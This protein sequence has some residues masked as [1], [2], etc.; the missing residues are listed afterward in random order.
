MRK[1]LLIIPILAFLLPGSLRAQ[2]TSDEAR[3]RKLSYYFMAA[4][5]A[6]AQ[7]RYA[8]MMEYL[9]HCQEIMPDDPATMFELGQYS[10][11][12]GMDSL[13]LVMIEQAVKADPGNPWYLERLATTY[14][15]R[16][17]RDQALE[18][19]EKMASLQTK[20]VDVL[21]Q[22]FML[23]KQMGRTED[24]IN[25]LDRIQMLQ[26]NNLRIAEQKYQLYLDME[27][28]G[29]ALEQLRAVCREFPY[30]VSSHLVLG[31]HYMENGML[32]SAVVCME[33]AERLDPYNSGLQLMRLRS[34]LELGDTLGYEHRRDSLILNPQ[35]DLQVRF[36]SMREV[37]LESLQ[38][39][40]KREHTSRIFDQLLGGEK[41]EVE[42]LQLFKSYDAYLHQEDPDYSN[43]DI[44]KR[45]V[46]ADPSVFESQIELAQYYIDHNEGANLREVCREALVYFPSET[47]F[48]YFLAITYLQ[49][50]MLPEAEETLKAGIRQA[51]EDESSGHIKGLLYGMLGDLCHEQHREKEAFAAYDSCLVYTPDE[52]SCL[53]NYAYY[54]SLKGE[55]LEKAE[56]MSYQAVKLQPANKTYL[57]TYAWVL[58]VQEDYT[59]ARIYMD[60][61]VNPQ[62]PDSVLLSDEDVNAVLLEHAGD[63]YANCGQMDVALRLWQL[64]QD[65]V[66]NDGQTAS[67]VLKKKLKKKKYLKK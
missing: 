44:L 63:I 8:D 58:F 36:I 12:L 27:Q 60:K 20:R 26:G 2:G 42:F 54:L 34:V 59:T 19:L 46:D 25:T 64:A 29:K 30:D 38:D 17:R 52:V 66:K 18:V 48:H 55:Q 28:P 50:K 32:D 4:Q 7:D 49:D 6:K 47:R 15:T 5:R 53:N 65:K 62:L 43:L 39:S 9:N 51:D 24:V 14:L 1:Y 31:E 3:R 56:R 41:V 45:I 67:V 10:Y 23:Y 21:S 16:G 35:T 37:A 11:A 40:L 61:V 33:R 22:L 13:G 57:D